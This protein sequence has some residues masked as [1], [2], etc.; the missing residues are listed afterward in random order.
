MKVM[1]YNAIVRPLQRNNGDVYCI[2]VEGQIVGQYL[3]HPFTVHCDFNLYWDIPRPATIASIADSIKALFNEAASP[4]RQVELDR[5]CDAPRFTAWESKR[6]LYTTEVS[7]FLPET[8]P[9]DVLIERG[10]QI[11]DGLVDDAVCLNITFDK[12]RNDDVIIEGDDVIIDVPSCD[13]KVTFKGGL[14][15][16]RLTYF[17]EHI[18]AFVNS[19]FEY[20]DII[21]EYPEPSE[22]NAFTCH[23]LTRAVKLADAFLFNKASVERHN[24]GTMN[25]FSS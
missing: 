5:L 8:A 25:I 12:E 2:E 20:E 22:I 7:F 18:S 17:I 3:D 6:G 16:E 4:K 23:P 15:Q 21:I 11:V 13:L 19:G 24:K 1:G 14:T 9:D 10:K